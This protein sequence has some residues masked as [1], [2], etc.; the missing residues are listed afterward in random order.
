MLY[1]NY[2]TVESMPEFFRVVSD[3]IE[4]LGLRNSKIVV[5]TRIWNHDRVGRMVASVE[6]QYPTH[7]VSV[8]GKEDGVS[9]TM[10]PYPNKR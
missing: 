1:N 3:I 8:N 5:N 4:N 7:K 10:E 6:R 2:K 9:I